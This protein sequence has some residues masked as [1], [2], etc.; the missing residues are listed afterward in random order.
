MN[1]DYIQQYGE[2][3]SYRG[4]IQGSLNNR[5]NDIDNTKNMKQN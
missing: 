4:D 1:I 5:R 3:L 2:V